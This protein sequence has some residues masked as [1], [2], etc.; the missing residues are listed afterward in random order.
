MRTG[1]YITSIEVDEVKL[2]PFPT[3]KKASI[4]EARS[5]VPR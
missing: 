5:F 1:K 4:E 3:D 2:T